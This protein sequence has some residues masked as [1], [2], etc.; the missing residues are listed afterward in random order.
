MNANPHHLCTWDENADC[1]ACG[2]Q[3]QLACKWDGQL[4]RVFWAT[5]LPTLALCLLGVSLVGLVTGRWWMLIGFIA[6]FLLMLGVLEIR[7]LCSHCPF[8]AEEGKILHCLANHG[9]FKFWKYRPE[10]MNGFERFLMIFLVATVFGIVPWAIEGYGIAFLAANR[11][12]FGMPLLWAMIGIT[13]ASVVAGGSALVIL[14]TVFCTQCV[15]FSCPLNTVP[16]PVVAAYLRRNP[17][18]REAW[19]A[20]KGKR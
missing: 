4:L 18:M 16:Q 1:A 20:A 10:P 17:V 9:S 6:Y 12:T 2:L 5:F 15:N 11:A 7:F 3:S 19:E 13:V 8:Y 14:R